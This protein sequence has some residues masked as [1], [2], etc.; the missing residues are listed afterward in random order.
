MAASTH[1]PAARG[2]LSGL[3]IAITRPASQSRDLAG[4]LEALGAR[5][6]SLSSI[7]IAPLDDPAQLDA[8]VAQ[9]ASYDWI[10]LTSVNGVA[11]LAERLAA[12]GLNWAARGSARFAVIGPATAGALRAHG[13]PPDLMPDEYVAEA[14]AVRLGAAAGQRILLLRA[15]IAR[16]A[17]A[18]DLRRSGAD[19]T[20]LAAYRTVVQPPDAALLRHLFQSDRPDAITFTSSSTV[21]GLLAG[22]TAL[23]ADPATALAGVTLAAIGPITANA[24][25]E[26]GLQPSVIASAYTIP[27][28]VAALV[29]H[30]AAQPAPR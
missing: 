26:H 5:V 11:A 22:L 15:D 7:A 19:V 23:G 8:A 16:K 20:E 3:H 30:Y 25:R 9:L 10:V 13:V 17:L 12:L 18:D 21:R 6:T 29:A 2:P 27:G 28:L 1:V 14:I 4:P 24:L